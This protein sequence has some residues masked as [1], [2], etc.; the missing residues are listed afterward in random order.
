MGNWSGQG[1][2]HLYDGEAGEPVVVQFGAQIVNDKCI[3]PSRTQRLPDI[4]FTQEPGQLY[5]VALFDHDAPYPH[6]NQNSPYLHE[7]YLTRDGQPTPVAPYLPMSPPRDSPAHRYEARVYMV[8]ENRADQLRPWVQHMTA[9]RGS[10]AFPLEQVE[11]QF[12]LQ[13]VGS[14]MYRAGY[15]CD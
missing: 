7:F 14:A 3:L 11:R 15:Q 2:G 1:Q 9:Q 8:P 6:R 10:A 4:L 13:A 5:A 12:D